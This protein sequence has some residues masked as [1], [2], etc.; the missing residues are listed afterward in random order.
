MF[1][2]DGK[3][4]EVPEDDGHGPEEGREDERKWALK[5]IL[6]KGMQFLYVYDFGDNWKHLVTVED[7]IVPASD[8]YL[9]FCVAGGR[10]CPPED[11]GGV[12]SYPDFLD[13]LA[14][15]RHPEHRE[16]VDWTRGFAPAAFNVTQAK[17]RKSVVEGKSVAVQVD[18][19][20]RCTIE[21]KKKKN[22]N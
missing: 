5:S 15:L 19:G 13:A 17:D 6:S 1:E 14:N 3:R 22:N 4:F 18:I 10:A 9:P 16:T 8:R 20:G 21:K 7:L 2:I 12:D 11:C